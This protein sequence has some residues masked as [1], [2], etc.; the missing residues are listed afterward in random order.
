MAMSKGILN[1]APLD[2]PSSNKSQPINKTVKHERREIE[3]LKVDGKAN[4][5]GY[6]KPQ[7]T[8]DMITQRP[9]LLCP[10]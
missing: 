10:P 7:P 6:N 8:Y 1:V 3:N 2:H 5:K 4:R 9:R